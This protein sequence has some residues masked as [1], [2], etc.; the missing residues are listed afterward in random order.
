MT[1][2]VVNVAGMWRCPSGRAFGC[3]GTTPIARFRHSASIPNARG[4]GGHFAASP[5]QS[6]KAVRELALVA[7]AAPRRGWA[8]RPQLRPAGI[9]RHREAGPSAWPRHSAAPGRRSS[10]RTRPGSTGEGQTRPHPPSPL[11]TTGRTHLAGRIREGSTGAIHA[12]AFPIPARYT[13]LAIAVFHLISCLGA[14]SAS[15][16]GKV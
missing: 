9:D 2:M 15:S 3:A 13:T 12:A 6:S 1:N 10:S 16:I 7:T 8:F 14:P 11:P 4:G 5:T